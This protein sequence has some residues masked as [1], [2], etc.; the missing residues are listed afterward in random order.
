MAATAP[1]LAS[2]GGESVDVSEFGGASIE[3]GG[4][5]DEVVIM[6]RL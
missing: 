6:V 4:W 5:L 3:R 2:K 1:A